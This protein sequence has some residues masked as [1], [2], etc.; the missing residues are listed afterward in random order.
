MTMASHQGA[1]A[2]VAG[3]LANYDSEWSAREYSQHVGLWPIEATLVDAYF[4]PAPAR[5]LDIGCGA[6]RTSAALH[7]R[8]YGVV[9]I[10]LAES[11][12]SIGRARHPGIDFCLMDARRLEYPDAAFD[13][14]LFSYNGIDNL[15]PEMSRLMCLREAAR[16]LKP[17]GV[18]IFSTH[19]FIGHFFSG[20]F[21]YPRGYLNAA[22]LIGQQLTNPLALEWYTR[23]ADGGGRQHL[24]SAPP[25]RT[26]RQVQAAGFDVIDTCGSGG[27]RRARR[28]LLRTPHVNFVVRRRAS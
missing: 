21:W 19:N 7:E 11:L 2:V 24:F 28:L 17:G 9:A 6:G 22:R 27:E 8:G 15:Y 13:A 12:L 26:A 10:D 3:N 18:L 23:Y 1:D 4:P 25:G 5:I 16:V 14:A 20:G